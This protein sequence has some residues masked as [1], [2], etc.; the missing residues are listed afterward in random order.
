M[1]VDNYQSIM[2]MKPLFKVLFV[3]ETGV[4]K[5]TLINVLTNHFRNGNPDNIKIAVKSQYFD[6][7]EKDLEHSFSEFNV[8]DQASSQT[9][10]CF[11]YDYEHPEHHKYKH[12]I[13]DSPGLSDTKNQDQRN[14]ELIAEKAID[15]KYLNAIVFVLNGSQARY[16]EVIK[17]TINGLNNYL[18]KSLLE[19]NLFL[20]L[21]HTN[22]IGANFKLDLFEKEVAI[23]KWQSDS[24]SRSDIEYSWKSSKQIIDNFLNA[25]K[26]NDF[27]STEDFQKIAELQR[28]L[29]A[30]ILKAVSEITK[31]NGAIFQLINA[32]YKCANNKNILR[33]SQNYTQ[34]NV[35]E[36]NE[37]VR[38]HYKN[39]IC[40]NHLD[41][42]CHENCPNWFVF[43]CDRI[44]FFRGECKE[45]GCNWS[46][47]D[48]Q[49]Y[50]IV[51]RRQTYEEVITELKDQYEELLFN[52]IELKAKEKKIISDIEFF[53]NG[54]ESCYNSIKHENKN[55]KVQHLRR[56]F[57]NE[58]LV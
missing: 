17:N 45:C 56:I 25:I 50:K 47:H 52:L 36:F 54:V 44:K 38:T 40:M 4:G 12:R 21:T 22:K 1:L 11:H 19:N 18:P 10:G 14:L 42:I 13:I 34:M 16:S 28:D 41:I 20:I 23:P 27:K 24:E 3:G 33:S 2:I 58:K 48:L 43:T 9:S 39:M 31:I 6:V 8:N 51:K 30:Q 29:N 49:K 46:D 26:D 57:E 35:V 37:C 15:E 55:L 53:V 32:R 7:T 5:S